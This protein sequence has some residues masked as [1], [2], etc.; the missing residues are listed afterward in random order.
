MNYQEA[1]DI[2]TRLVSAEK[3]PLDKLQEIA[4]LC[5]DLQLKYIG[6]PTAVLA[7]MVAFDQYPRNTQEQVSQA[8]FDLA[9]KLIFSEDHGEINEMLTGFHK[10]A[11]AQSFENL[12]EFVDGAIDSIYV[13]L[14]TLLKFNVPVQTCFD[15]VQ[16]SNMA[17][18]H[19][20]GSYLKKDGK[21]VKPP[22]WT[23]PNLHEILVQHFGARNG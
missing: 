10:F 20:D 22:G 19:A 3:L 12:A 6:M 8:D 17:K 23:P 7:F 2:S 13:I 16:R 5:S 18:L 15:E 21:V 11:K 1:H 14:W 4:V 9:Y